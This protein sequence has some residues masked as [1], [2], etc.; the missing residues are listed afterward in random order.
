MLSR[1][2]DF[3]PTLPMK[4]G[5]HGIL[6]CLS[7]KI[8][9]FSQTWYYY[10]TGQNITNLILVYLYNLQRL[11]DN[12]ILNFIRPHHNVLPKILSHIWDKNHKYKVYKVITFNTKKLTTPYLTIIQGMICLPSFYQQS[13]RVYLSCWLYL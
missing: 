2:F 3:Y 5:I 1:H 11:R 9:Y 13:L 4:Y 6:K 12:G 8:D 10:W 7:I